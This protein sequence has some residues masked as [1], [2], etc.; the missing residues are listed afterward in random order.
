MNSFF[1]LEDFIRTIFYNDNGDDDNEDDQDDESDD[2]SDDEDVIIGT[3]TG[4]KMLH[5]RSRRLEA[6]TVLNLLIKDYLSAP[7]AF[8]LCASTGGKRNAVLFSLT[9]PPV[10]PALRP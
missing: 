8:G 4:L 5:K 6:K 3:G 1:L 9:H 2:K 7:A 10:Q